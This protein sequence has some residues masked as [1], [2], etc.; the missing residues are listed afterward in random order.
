MRKICGIYDVGTKGM[1]YY[2]YM[3]RKEEA[4]QE[5]GMALHLHNKL[6]KKRFVKV[7]IKVDCMTI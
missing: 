1:K 7:G 3:R 2:I 5:F 6:V 4:T